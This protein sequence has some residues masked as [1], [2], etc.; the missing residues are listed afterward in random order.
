VRTIPHETTGLTCAQLKIDVNT[1]E[2]QRIDGIVTS[3]KTSGSDADNI[4]TILSDKVA[5]IKSKFVLDLYDRI[6]IDSF[7][8]SAYN[9]VEIEGASKKADYD[10]ILDRCMKNLDMEKNAK[11]I[12]LKGKPYA[13]VALNAMPKL[14]DA[15]KA[16]L[17]CFLS[18]APVV[19]RFH[20]D[21]DGFSGAI[22]LYRALADLQNRLFIN[23]RNVF[24]HINRS[25]AYTMESASEDL[26]FFSTYKSIEKPL[27]FITDF[28]TSPESVEAIDQIQDKCELI[29]IDHH[30][31]YEGF[32]REKASHYINS[33]DLGGNS[34]STAGL[35]TCMFSQIIG[36]IDAE[37]LKQ[38]SL[39]SDYSEYADLKNIEAHKLSLVMDF[40]TSGKSRYDSQGTTPKQIES[41]INDRERF[42]EVFGFATKLLDEAL[43]VGLKNIKSYNSG[44]INVHVLDFGHVAKLGFSYPLPGRY[45]SKLQ[46]HMEALNN[47]STITMIHYGNYISIRE[48][49]DISKQVKLLSIIEKMKE[50]GEALSGGGHSEAAS[51]RVDGKN[52]KD[53]LRSLLN[54]FGVRAEA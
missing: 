32:Q 45:S 2:N 8:S 26:M 1:M 13:E 12:D 36:S 46:E 48:S 14:M 27:M 19:I 38:A 7:D 18:G 24:W 54:E 11:R 10:D 25:I 44:R 52:I 39:I 21:G 41:I 47:G 34:N 30:L 15:A 31:P 6:S 37:L 4:Y 28:G 20:N 22:A 33:W 51:I 40:L 29:W 5:Q 3:I 50:S 9:D 42:E 53:A 49:H 16:F 35:L 17:R 43:E 23:E